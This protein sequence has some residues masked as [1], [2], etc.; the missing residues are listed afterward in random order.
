MINVASSIGGGGDERQLASRCRV[1]RTLLIACFL[2]SSAACVGGSDVA[3]PH[4]ASL[5][6]ER[7][8]PDT[9]VIAIEGID[10]N[11]SG[12]AWWPG[13]DSLLAVI[14]SPAG[15]AHISTEGRLIH[16]IDLPINDPEGIVMIDAQHGYVSSEPGALV[17]IEVRLDDEQGL[18]V[19]FGAVIEVGEQ[20]MGNNGLEGV[21]Y[22]AERRRLYTVK[23]RQPA[24]LYQIDLPAEDA[25]EAEPVVRRLLVFAPDTVD[26]SDAAGC[27]F[28]PKTGHLLVLSQEDRLLV[29]M[30][31]EGREISRRSLNA[32]VQ[33]EGVTA[34]DAGNLYIVGEPDQFVRF[35]PGEKTP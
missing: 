35:A 9:D 34:D 7:Y 4:P 27:V 25:P 3:E 23:E 16:A 32:L 2:I 8:Q 19:E 18:R 1:A 21:T 26:L 24:A 15:L 11:L 22:D 17:P 6:L 20:F 5:D 30:T 13:H 28:D 10:W 29:E 14:N 12:V 31:L 33:P